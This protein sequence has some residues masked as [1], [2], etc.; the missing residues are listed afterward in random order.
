MG[1][2]LVR[3]KE[4][5]H[6]II[7]PQYMNTLKTYR[8]VPLV[9]ILVG[10]RHC[11][12]STILDML[13]DDLQSTEI[14]ADHIIS[15]RYTSE[16]FDDGM[17]DKDMYRS[18]KEQMTDDGRYYLL[19]DEVQ[20][21]SGWEK[22][23][24]SLLE[25]ANTDIYVTGSNSKLMPSEISTY[26]TGRYISIPVYTLSFGEYLDFKKSDSRSPRELLNQYLRLGGFPIVALG[27][28]DERS[29]YQ[30][31]ESIYNSVITNDITKRHNIMNFDL[32]NRVV[33]YIVE[34]V[35][36]TFSANAI[37]NF[38]KSEGRSLSVEAVYNYLNWLE[39]A[40]V[41]YRCQRYDL[42]VKSVLKTQ[43]KFYLADTSLKY[44][45]MGFNPKS[46]AAML[47]NIVYFELRRRGYEVYIGK[48]E[49]KEIDFVAVRRDERIYVQVCRRLPEE[50]DREVAN[51]LEIKDHYPQYVVTL[52]ELAAGNIN[53]VK[54]VHLADFLLSG[55]Y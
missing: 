8:D 38:L 27:N 5:N 23:V 12:K 1:I 18:I 41:I 49:T 29:S 40:F 10:I 44:C 42:R 37:A 31:V 17:T 20:E 21:I 24:N 48:N 45:I 9:K 7:R 46:I 2:S 26:L 30:I 53:G 14:A 54:I 50:S 47:E 11:G 4:A 33:K 34:N 19:L 39:K 28:F 3:T 13:R 25:N 32:F 52:D 55:E 6:M 35:G 16:D 22:A 15:M 36:K 43:E 51:L